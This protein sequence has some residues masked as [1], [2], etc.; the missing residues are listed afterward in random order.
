MCYTE[1]IAKQ[2]GEVF[3]KCTGKPLARIRLCARVYGAALPKG[4]NDGDGSHAAEG[5][6]G[7]P[8]IIREELIPVLDGWERGETQT[9]QLARAE[10][11]RLF[12]GQIEWMKEKSHF[13]TS[14]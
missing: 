11:R 12:A 9:R 10:N 3:R 5:S 6:E 7:I 8:K 14:R 4:R 1:S 13:R 2:Y